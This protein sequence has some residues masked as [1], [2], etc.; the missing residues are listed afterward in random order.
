MYF[1]L[2]RVIK[3]ISHVFADRYT[4][5]SRM[6][7]YENTIDSTNYYAR[8]PPLLAENLLPRPYVANWQVNISLYLHDSYQEATRV[9]LFFFLLVRIVWANGECMRY[10]RIL[11]DSIN[12][13]Y[14]P[15]TYGGTVCITQPRPPWRGNFYRDSVCVHDESIAP[16]LIVVSTQWWLKVKLI[17]TQKKN[18]YQINH[19][20]IYHIG[21]SI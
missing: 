6:H 10:R 5:G 9:F 17:R 2:R 7:A 11:R 16:H 14:P 13:A 20:L 18:Y 1:H 19:I 15:I 4:E 8:S 21:K 3:L 12:S